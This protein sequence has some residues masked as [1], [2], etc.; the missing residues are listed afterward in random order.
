MITTGKYELVD[1][2]WVKAVNINFAKV[3]SVSDDRFV[4]SGKMLG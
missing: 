3:T 4:G 1:K 2:G